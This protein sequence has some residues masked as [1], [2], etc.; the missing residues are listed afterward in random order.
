MG[1]SRQWKSHEIIQ[2]V[3]LATIDTLGTFVLVYGAHWEGADQIIKEEA[4]KL[5]IQLEPHPA[6]WAKY[7]QAGRKKNPAGQIRNREMA[8]S[9]LALYVGFRAFGPSPGTDGMREYCINAGVPTLII[10]EHMDVGR[11]PNA[12]RSR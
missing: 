8:E 5:G 4:L 2:D 12:R 1:G 7:A 9:G 6:D 3:L 11:F 10:P